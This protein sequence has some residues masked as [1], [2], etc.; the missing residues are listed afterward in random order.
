MC[1]RHNTLLEQ[2]Q[3][4]TSGTL[5]LLRPT[6][7]AER[8]H[9]PSCACWWAFTVHATVHQAPQSSLYAILPHHDAVVMMHVLCCCQILENAGL[10]TL[11]KTLPASE[12]YTYNYEGNAQVLDHI[13]ASTGLFAKL[14]AY[15]S[16]HINSEFADQLSDHDP[17]VARFNCK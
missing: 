17:S 5:C 16:V 1:C 14:D 13:A 4:C 3:Y 2:T 7:C 8:C 9:H 12:Q 11:V 6:P 10:R 15:D